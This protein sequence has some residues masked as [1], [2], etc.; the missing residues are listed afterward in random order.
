[1]A[2]SNLTNPRTFFDVEI[3]GKKIGRVVFQLYADTVPRTAENFRALC[4][5]EK[6]L[7][8][9]TGLRLHYKGCPFHRII[10]NFMIQGG[11]F[12]HKNGTG[13]E[14]IYGI[15]FNDENF[16]HKHT[17]PG[18]LS[19][20]N[21]GPNTNRSQFFITT[22]AA[23]HL[24]GKHV[25]FGRVVHGM[26]VLD[27]LNNIL[28]DGNDTPFA[29]AI[30]ANSGELVLQIPKGME[31]LLA[32]KDEAASESSSSSESESSSES[33]SDDERK[34]KRKDKRQQKKEE[35]AK[36]K[37]EKQKK[38]EEKKAKKLAKQKEKQ[39]E[40]EKS[41]EVK[42]KKIAEVEHSFLWRK[43]RSRSR[44]PKRNN[45]SGSRD[46][47]RERD[48]ERQSTV[49]YRDGVRM[50]GRGTMVFRGGHV[51]DSRKERRRSPPRRYERQSRRSRSRSKSGSPQRWE[52]DHHASHSRSR[53][54]SPRRSSRSPG[55]P[56]RSRSPPRRSRSPRRSRRSGSRSPRR[57]N[58]N[59]NNNN[60]NN[61]NNRNNMTEEELRNN[62]EQVKKLINMSDSDSERSPRKR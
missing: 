32:K 35:K 46:R 8:K 59:H 22:G 28:T 43:S 2:T 38:K 49:R 40:E 34:K 18:I 10:K 14:S 23:P 9:I 5:G 31:A 55:R 37:S 53:S 7:S 3:D 41:A 16:V 42:R 30:I 61:N 27:I 20:A 57:N 21:A 36:K 58:H 11:D 60:N 39:A 56:R 1:M 24:D 13:G 25:V 47:D 51:D 52:H 45:R 12:Q 50:K 19:M 4:T 17:G 48:R 44:S 29:K 6:G 33:S 26:D 15:K 62:E 54:R